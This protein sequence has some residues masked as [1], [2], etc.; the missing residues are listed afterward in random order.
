M[1]KV[2]LILAGFCVSLNAQASGNVNSSIKFPVKTDSQEVT[3]ENFKCESGESL[4][5]CL[6]RFKA[7]KKMKSKGGEM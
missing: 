3:V 4:K 6:D 1:T 7:A 2:F 5:S